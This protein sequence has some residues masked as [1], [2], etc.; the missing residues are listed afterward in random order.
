MLKDKTIAVIRG[1]KSAERK[2]SLKTGKAIIT[3]LEKKGYQVVDIDP[4]DNLHQQLADNQIDV[5]FIALHGRYGEDGTIQGF[6]EIE[7]TPY[8]GSGVLG[9]A[10]AMDK[11]RSKRIFEQAGLKT[12]KFIAFNQIEYQQQGFKVK[13]AVKEKLSFPVVVKPALE[14]SSLGLSIIKSEDQL[15]AAVEEAFNYDQQILI[16]EYIPGKEI[17]V[18][19]LGTE[20]LE[21]LPVIEIRPK[22][23]VYDYEAKYTKGATEFV[24]PAE[25]DQT[26][27]EKAQ[28]L[29][30]QAHQA[31]GC[32]GVSRV[33][34]RVT[35]Q[36][37]V[38]ILEVNTIPG[39]TETSLLPQAAA[40]KGLPFPELVEQILKLAVD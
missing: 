3:A 13:T 6:L 8:T 40:E 23:G 5:A 29:A 4:K 22:D 16:E 11:I 24:I 7:E 12:P 31:L 25:L 14:G 10:L 36:G 18:G 20:E 39:M 27:Y 37:E 1:G 32:R 28:D 2:I 19:L 35:P 21:V 33:D 30:L 26:V 34:L 15:L 17:T 9:S 38:H